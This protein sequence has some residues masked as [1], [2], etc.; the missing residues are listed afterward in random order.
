MIKSLVLNLTILTACMLILSVNL[1]GCTAH[2]SQSN[3]HTT[4]VSQGKVHTAHVSQGKVHTAHHVKGDVTQGKV[5]TARK[6]KHDKFTIEELMTLKFPTRIS[7]DID[8]DPCKSRKS[9]TLLLS[10]NM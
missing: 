6:S 2:V 1:I 10:H 7:D 3:V 9:F 4:H 8:A 5:H